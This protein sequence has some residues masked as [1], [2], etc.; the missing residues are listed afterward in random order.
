MHLDHSYHRFEMIYRADQY[1][2]LLIQQSHRQ[3]CH[4]LPLDIQ[5]NAFALKMLSGY[6][7]C[8][9]FSF[10]PKNYSEFC[11]SYCY[12]SRCHYGQLLVTFTIHCCYSTQLQL[13]ILKCNEQQPFSDVIKT[14][15][16]S[17]RYSRFSR[18]M[19]KKYRYC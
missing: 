11:Y 5:P 14:Q 13:A 1:H 6:C 2:S 4:L 16:M 17:I 19:K 15:I 12:C 18:K 9:M 7:C 10:K 3:S 8:Q